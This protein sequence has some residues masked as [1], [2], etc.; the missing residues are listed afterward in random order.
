MKPFIK[1]LVSLSF[2]FALYSCQPGCQ[3]TRTFQNYSSKAVVVT[4]MFA[5]ESVTLQPYDIKTETYSQD[6]SFKYWYENGYC[7]CSGDVKFKLKDSTKIITKDIKNCDNWQR[8]AQ[9]GSFKSGRFSCVFTLN[10][11]DIK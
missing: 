2:I 1:T 10:D 6:G 3:F 4:N 9:K 11:S 5:V 7:A 8:A